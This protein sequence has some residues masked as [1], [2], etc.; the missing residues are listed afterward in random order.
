[1]LCAATKYL[2][3]APFLLPHCGWAAMFHQAAAAHGISG[4][5]RA[6]SHRPQ[7]MAAWRVTCGCYHG[8]NQWCLIAVFSSGCWARPVLASY[9][10]VCASRFCNKK[11]APTRAALDLRRVLTIRV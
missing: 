8:D 2:N 6:S 7:G 5:H 11:A 4:L 10:R 9:L 1:L 3:S